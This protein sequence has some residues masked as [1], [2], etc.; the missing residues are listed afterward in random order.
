MLLKFVKCLHACIWFSVLFI[1]ASL[2]YEKLPVLYDRFHLS[3]Y[4]DFFVMY[5]IYLHW[6]NMGS[7]FHKECVCFW[8]HNI[9]KY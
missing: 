1:T 7:T 8:Q 4:I 9:C 5:I 6:I 2:K 3:V